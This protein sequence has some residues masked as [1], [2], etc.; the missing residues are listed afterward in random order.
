MII[1]M[2]YYE[3]QAQLEK[4]LKSISNAKVI[5]VDDCS[6]TD[7]VLPKL[8]YPVEVIKIKEKWWTNPEP[9]YN[10]GL[11]RAL[12]FKDD[13]IIQNAECYHVGDVVGYTQANLTINNYLAFGCF[14]LDKENTF[15]EHNIFELL[16]EQGAQYRNHLSWYN[17]PIYRP[18]AFEFCAAI[19]RENIIKLNGYDERFSQGIGCGDDYL[20]HRVRQLGLRVEIPVNPF[21][22]HQW[23]EDSQCPPNARELRNKNKALISELKTTE[24][25]AKHLYTEDL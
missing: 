10:I 4:T 17:H 15:K 11:K 1:V 23:H 12:D 2:T 16:N 9:A 14:S 3:R 18:C 13:I 8:N 22:V 25:R 7:I 19:K 24:Y 5:I 20:L 6:P 21:V